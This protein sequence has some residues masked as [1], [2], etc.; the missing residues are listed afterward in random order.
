L[1]QLRKTLEGKEVSPTGPATGLFFRWDEDAQVTWIAATFPV[2]SA[3][4]LGKD[5]AIIE[6]PQSKALLVTYKGPYEGSADAHLA[7]DSYIEKYAL[8]QVPPVIEEYLAGPSEETDPSK[9][10]TR[11]YYLFK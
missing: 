8:T 2:A 1:T 6:V 3:V 5:G 9:W 4:D 11:I 7:I 10:V